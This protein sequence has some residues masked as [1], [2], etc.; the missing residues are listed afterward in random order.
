MTVYVWAQKRYRRLIELWQIFHL[1]Y[2]YHLINCQTSGNWTIYIKIFLAHIGSFCLPVSLS[3][4]PYLFFSSLSLILS[5]SLSPSYLCMDCLFLYSA[6]WCISL[7]FIVYESWNVGE[8]HLRDFLDL[9]SHG[10]VSNGLHLNTL[11][12]VCTHFLHQY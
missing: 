3:V 1:E 10:M 9:T 11:F 6:V 7:S 2:K 5:R 12:V 8:E 4:C